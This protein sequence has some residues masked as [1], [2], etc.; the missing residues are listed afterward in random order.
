M[1]APVWASHD[2]DGTC[3]LGHADWYDVQND[4]LD[5]S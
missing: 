4:I 1:L 3:L 5:M 2:T